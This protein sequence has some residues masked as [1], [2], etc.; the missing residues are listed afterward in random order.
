[1][2]T[3]RSLTTTVHDTIDNVTA[4]VADMHRSIAKFPLT[5]LAEI[6]PFKATLDEVKATQDSTIEAVYGL[7]RTINARVRRLTSR[8]PR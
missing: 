5:V 1:M 6:I 8:A 3:A 2:S 4:E 7:V